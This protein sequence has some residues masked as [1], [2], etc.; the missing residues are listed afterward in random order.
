M[1]IFAEGKSKMLSSLSL[2]AAAVSGY[3]VFKSGTELFSFLEMYSTPAFSLGL[4]KA[5]LPVEMPPLARILARDMRAAFTFAF[6]FWLSGFVLALGVFLRK[7]W[8][9]RGACWMLYLLSA[10]ALLLLLFPG[11]AIPRPLVYGG[12]SLAPEFNAVVRAA[13]F[14]A[15]IAALL[16]GGLCL[17]WALA[18]DRGGLKKEF[19][20][21]GSM[22]TAG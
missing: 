19:Q 4:A 1:R 16:A 17:W 3:L 11:L 2:A 14:S 8:A 20:P 18:L 15:R 6:V 12:V 22:K 7:E 9:R 13:A 21:A 10:A 5:T